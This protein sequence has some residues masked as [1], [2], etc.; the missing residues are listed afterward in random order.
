MHERKYFQTKIIPAVGVVLCLFLG[1]SI[2]LAAAGNSSLNSP[3]GYW[4]TI[5]DKEGDVRSIVKIWLA[6]DG[7]LKGRIEKLYPRPDEEADPLCDKCPG[8]RKN[9]RVI[10][11]EFMWGFKGSGP[12]WK[13]GKILDPENGKTYNCQLEVVD[14]GKKIEV[15]GYIR[16]IFKIGRTQTWVRSE[17]PVEKVSIKE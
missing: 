2:P 17:A 3:V 9:Q 14:N 15:F 16:I 13:G 6:E 10:G 8:K 7:T 1:I 5:D 11:M 4:K 12:I